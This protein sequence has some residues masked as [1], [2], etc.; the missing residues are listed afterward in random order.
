MEKYIATLVNGLTNDVRQ[1]QIESLC[2]ELAHKDIYFKHADKS[3]EI[4]TII[5]ESSN[6]VYSDLDGFSTMPNW[7]PEKQPREIPVA[8]DVISTSQKEE[9]INY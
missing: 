7:A 8:P 2:P 5:D 9:E 1:V 3:E 4:K 6:T